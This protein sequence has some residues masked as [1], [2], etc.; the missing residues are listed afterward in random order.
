MSQEK[1]PMRQRMIIVNFGIA[2]GLVYE[3]WRGAPLLIVLLCG[4][5]FFVLAN[6]VM[7]F[8]IRKSKTDQV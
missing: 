3:Y 5:F 1:M 8:K 4:V 7:M 6:L 2:V